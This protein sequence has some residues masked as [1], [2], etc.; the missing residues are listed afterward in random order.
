VFAIPDKIQTSGWALAARH[1]MGR[2][3]SQP[4][5]SKE[6]PDS[7]KPA[8]V[9]PSG[10]PPY[11]TKPL[12][13]TPNS[14]APAPTEPDR[15]SEVN[16]E[17]RRLNRALRA[18]SACNKAL[19]QAGSEQALLREICDIIVRVGG[20]RFSWIGYADPGVEKVVRPMAFGG[21]ED[22]Y[23]S[24]VEVKWSDTPTGR[25][26][27]GTAIRENRICVV[28]DAATDPSFAQWRDAALARGYAAIISM[29]LRVGGLAFGVLGIYSDQA[30]SFDGSEV[31]LLTEIANNLAFG[32]TALRSQEERRRTTAALEDAE[33]KYRQLVEEVPAISYVAESGAL[34]PFVYMS[35]QVETILGFRPE[36]CLSDPHFWWNHLHPDDRAQALQEDT[37][38]EGRLFQIEYRILRHDG[39]QV[40]VRDEA[41]IVRDPHTGKRLTRGVL[42]DITDQKRAEGALRRSEESYRMFV[43]ESSEGIF[44]HDL[45]APLPIDLPEEEL[46]HRVIHDSYL[47]ECNDA[48]AKMYALNS[49][50]ELIGKRLT[51]LLMADDPHNIEMARQYVRNGFRVVDRESHEI[52]ARGNPKIFLNSMF[53]V[54]EDRKLLHT[55]GI[56]RDITER[57]KAERARQQAEDAL[58]ESETA[59]L[60]PKARKESIVW[61]TTRRFR[62][63]C[64]WR[65]NWLGAT[66]PDTWRNATMPWRR[67]TGV[68]QPRS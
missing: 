58:R 6:L 43:A 62:A 17:L 48:M 18:L 56:Q 55:W 50:R 21:H 19:A 35:P 67:C 12:E 32:I 1:T 36:E 40:W 64:H 31:E 7:D 20:Y 41:I 26:P 2:S 61:S 44:R 27:S 54:V 47:A 14:A 52:D 15:D 49:P 38:E 3:F 65:S 24:N 29:P 28:T 34:G 39:Q 46:I 57:L 30:G 25:G 51:E 68:H 60:S 53:G 4:L 23:L 22:G 59:L 66:R 42:I 10:S 13:T 37:W 8:G 16:K 45:D 11:A 5:L 9:E 63:T 33:A